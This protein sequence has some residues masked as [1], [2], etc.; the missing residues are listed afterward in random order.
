MK[1]FC[2]LVFIWSFSIGVLLAEVPAIDAIYNPL[3][4]TVQFYPKLGTTISPPI[5]QLFSNDELILEFDELSGEA[6]SYYFKI[7]HCNA[8]WTVSNL[9][10][11]Q[12]VRDFNETFIQDRQFSISTKTEFTHYSCFM[13]PML[14]SGNFLVKVYEE[15][16]EDH[17]M[18]TRRFNVVENRISI[19]GNVGFPNNTSKVRTHQM[20]NFKIDYSIY[21]IVNPAAQLKVIVRQN[22]VWE[23]ATLPLPPLYI[24]EDAKLLDYSFYNDETTFPGGNEYRYFDMRSFN[25]RGFNVGRVVK[26]ELSTYVLLGIDNTRNSSMYILWEDLNGKFTTE[27][28]ETGGKRLEA[29]YAK[30]NFMLESAELED[31]NVYVYGAL[32]NWELAPE[33]RMVYNA[34]KKAYEAQ[35]FLKQ[36]IY[37][38]RYFVKGLKETKDE[39]YFE[40][41][42]SAAE[43]QYDILVYY[44]IPGEFYDR[45]I[46]YQSYR[47]LGGTRR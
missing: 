2:V 14:V 25:F 22:F 23:T 38:Y 12:F 3:I 33:N 6:N 21:N 13:P 8:D 5:I 31:A 35:L 17:V 34:E 7:I 26:Q 28:Y 15:G 41:N 32:S 29:D 36:G 40:G 46:G 20:L 4:K 10:S 27:N 45:I 47:Y 16:N 18:L 43:N 11:I 44:R 37:N 1:K 19:I 30:V 9:R 24:M 42:Y 39:N